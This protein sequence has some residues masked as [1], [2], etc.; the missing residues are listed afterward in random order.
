MNVEDVRKKVAEIS[1]VSDEDDEQAHLSEDELYQEVMEAIAN[2]E[3]DDPAGC[4]KEALKTL[5]ID[6]SRWC[7]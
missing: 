3:C 2:G 6:F 4:A 7:A 5:D 1:A